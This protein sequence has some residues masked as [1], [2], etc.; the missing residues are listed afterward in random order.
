MGMEMVTIPIGEVPGGGIS[1]GAFSDE[2]GGVVNLRN[3]PILFRP[4]RRGV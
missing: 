2:S 1:A 4:Y 3:L